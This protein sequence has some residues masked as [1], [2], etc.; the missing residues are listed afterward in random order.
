M[1]GRFLVVLH[2]GGDE[3]VVSA[4]RSLEEAEAAYLSEKELSGSPTDEKYLAF[5]F[6]Q[7]ERS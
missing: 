4:Y 7:K 2:D 3:W 6:D 1:K 5:I